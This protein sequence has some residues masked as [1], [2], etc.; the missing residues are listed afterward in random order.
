MN[1]TLK[2]IEAEDVYEAPLLTE[3]GAYAEVTQGW[4]GDLLEGPASYQY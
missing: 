4:L 1:D 2:S 3:A